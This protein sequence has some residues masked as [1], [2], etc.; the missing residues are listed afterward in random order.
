MAGTDIIE[1][2]YCPP[3]LLENS[4]SEFHNSPIS[5]MQWK[6]VVTMAADVARTGFNV[7]HDLGKW[8]K[9]FITRPVTIPL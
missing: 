7:T 4:K 6:N 3:M 9:N 1:F 2:K 5:S 8:F